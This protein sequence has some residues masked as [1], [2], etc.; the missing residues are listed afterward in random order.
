MGIRPQNQSPCKQN[1]EDEGQNDNNGDIQH[2]IQRLAEIVEA[3]TGGISFVVLQFLRAIERSGYILYNEGTQQWDI[4]LQKVKRMKNMSDDVSRVVAKALRTCN[5]QLKAAL[6]VA[7]SFGVSQ[8][9]TTTIVHAIQAVDKETSADMDD[10]DGD[11][12]DNPYVVRKLVHEMSGHLAEAVMEGYLVEACNGTFRFAHDRIREAAYSL[13]PEFNGNQSVHLK[14]G[15]KI[16]SWMD[17]QSELGLFQGGFSKESLLLLHA[18]KQL[19]AG[20]DLITDDWELIDLADL[21]YQAAELAATKTAFISAMDYLQIG[22]IHL[23]G[24]ESWINHFDRALRFHDALAR[25]QYC[26]GRLDKCWETSESVI[27][28]GKTFAH[29][30][31]VY[32]TRILCLMQNNLMNDALKLTLEALSILEVKIPRHCL[33]FHAMRAYMKGQSFVK[34]RSAD[35]FLNLPLVECETLETQ[36]D[37]LQYLGELGFLLDKI[38]YLILAVYQYLMLIEKKGNYPRSFFVTQLWAGLLRDP[39]GDF[40]EAFR[41]GQVCN[42]MS[43]KH[44][45]AIPQFVA[46]VYLHF[47]SYIHHWNR[48]IRESLFANQHSLQWL[49]NCG[50]VDTA[51][52]EAAL[53]LQH[54][55]AAG[56]SLEMIEAICASYSEA[57]IDFRQMTHWYI[58][59]SQHQALHKLL[60]RS[61]NPSVLSGDL[62]DT[63]AFEKIWKKSPNPPAL[64]NMQ[65]FEMVLG[66]HLGNLPSAK[67]NI[68]AMRKDIFAEGPCFFVPL[69]LFYTSLV[70]FALFRETKASKY[71]R[72]ARL[73]WK[74]LLQLA[75]RGAVNSIY[76]CKLLAAEDKGLAAHGPDAFETVHEAYA[77]AIRAVTELGLVHH[78]ALANE[79]A[80][81]Y[82]LS[83][84]QNPLAAKYLNR[85]VDFYEQWGAVSIVYYLKF[86]YISIFN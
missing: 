48:P 16:R 55:F 73:S 15:R 50:D 43:E 2:D 54:L 27:R 72:R 42:T 59:V 4:N 82:F 69:R 26:C 36:L 63:E 10:D 39:K 34:N 61:E 68:K 32:R 31:R 41:Y 1:L 57:F 84:G 58:N 19:N 81:S 12:D 18:T 28:H 52:L 45:E 66:Y 62:I 5:P 11:Y 7:A 40:A 85:A 37:F 46:R 38:E 44:R 67:K 77:G 6:V 56:E 65:F 13:L 64:F 33:S 24:E 3:K 75:S 76:M 79:L 51:L 83:Q 35:Y 78:M 29:K 20:S 30:S 86:R 25:M 8:F 47:F 70:Y 22:I 21:N 74:R 17:T 23:G 14:I 49:W 53:I 71:L 80:G 60:G 9:D